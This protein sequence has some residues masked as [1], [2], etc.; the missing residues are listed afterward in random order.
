MVNINKKTLGK[1][2][3]YTF[4]IGFFAHGYAFANFQPSHDS[5]SEIISTTNVMEWKIQ[6]GRYLKPVY[7]LIFGSFSALPWSNGIFALIWL[8]IAVYFM[9][10]VLE[11][12]KDI[13]IIFIS[14]IMVTNLS[15]ISLIATYSQDLAS[16]M[17]ALAISMFGTYLWKKY[18]MDIKDGEFSKKQLLIVLP[19]GFCVT[20]S[21]A[22]YQAF[23][24]VFVTMVLIVSVLRCLNSENWKLTKIWISDFLA[25]GSV[26]V[27]GIIYYVFMKL[28]THLTNVS[29]NQQNYNSVSNTWSNTESISGRIISCLKQFFSMFFKMSGYSCS[30]KILQFINVIFLLLGCLFLIIV[31]VNLFKKKIPL[32]YGFSLLFFIFLLPF[33][34]NGIRLLNTEVHVLTMYA[35]WFSYI[36]VIAM[37]FECSK[38]KE[39]KYIEKIIL[40]LLFCVMLINVQTANVC[41]VKKTTEQEATL[42]LMTRVVDRIDDLDGYVAGVTPV[43]FIGY[44]S[45]Y[46]MDYDLFNEVSSL[47]GLWHNSPITYYSIYNQY[48]KTIMKVNIN[49]VRES[50]ANETVGEEFI[51]NMPE[52]SKKESICIKDGIVIVKF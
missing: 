43:V 1:S 39:N 5:L 35:F 46:L 27:G 32:G 3:L 26:I 51:K 45:Q 18:T 30:S 7:D 28:I 23:L 48:F 22:L 37:A 38:I 25:C 41:Y 6:L 40:V 21:L 33:S 31:F 24:C 8:S 13:H 15:V 36:L 10:E 49:I 44:P 12:R 29:L 2:F 14:G 52:F 20:L 42:S 50:V 19:V 16:D 9:V 47:T 11:F 34:M 4:I 17:C